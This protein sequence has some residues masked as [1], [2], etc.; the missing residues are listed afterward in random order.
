MKFILNPRAGGGKYLEKIIGWIHQTFSHREIKYDVQITQG[1]GDGT[2]FALEAIREGYS[3]VV[4]V[5][6]D[7]TINEVATALVHQEAV[8][9]IIPVGS[10]NGLARTLKI[11][12]TWRKACQ[13]LLNGHIRQIDVGKLDGRYFFS[14]AGIGFEAHLGDLYDKRVGS[15]RGIWPYFFLAAREFFRFQRSEVTLEFITTDSKENKIITCKPFLITVANTGQFGGGAIIAP[16]A[17]PDDGVFNLCIIHEIN[18]LQALYHA[19]KL[20][21]GEITRMPQMERYPIT[22]LK[23]IQKSS[24]LAHVDGEPVVCGPACK[25]ILL[26][27]ALK[28]LTN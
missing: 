2:K 23:I 28:V 19:P 13:L 6:G 27:Q 11:P 8:L 5:G 16:E 15:R 22:E 1:Q 18:F 25:V 10:G 4:A 14:N 24:V 17:L 9:G 3:R 21:T 20:F 26:H 12:L 7:G